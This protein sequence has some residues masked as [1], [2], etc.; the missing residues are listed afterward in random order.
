MGWCCSFE[1]LRTNGGFT[2]NETVAVFVSTSALQWVLSFAIPR[3][4]CGPLLN[5]N[6]ASHEVLPAQPTLST[7]WTRSIK[8]N[9]CNHVI[10][11]NDKP[12]EFLR[13]H[14]SRMTGN[15]NLLLMTF[16][17]FQFYALTCKMVAILRNLGINNLR[18][19]KES[20]N[21]SKNL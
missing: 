9:C 1:V 6:N 19:C 20:Q 15:K 10:I 7:F 16:F 21:W 17:N 12:T 14:C 3:W 2:R 11:I 5:K 13:S 8:I 4:Q 18:I